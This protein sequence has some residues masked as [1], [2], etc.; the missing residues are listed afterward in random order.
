MLKLS[1]DLRRF[2]AEYHHPIQM[3]PTHLYFSALPFAPKSSTL[4]QIFAKVFVDQMP[5]VLTGSPARWNDCLAVMRGSSESVTSVSFS[6]DGALIA[7][8]AWDDDLIRLWDGNTGAPMREFRSDGVVRSLSFVPD[9]LACLGYSSGIRDLTNGSL[10]SKFTIATNVNPE[11][12]ST[13]IMAL[14]ADGRLMASSQG[15]DY[16]GTSLRP[17]RRP[18]QRHNEFSI[19][20]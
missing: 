19:L 3:N 12:E 7:S 9:G 5:S 10:T 20:T 11:G 16:C 13:V 4:F 1:Y 15:I 18:H 8:I 17:R 2:V 14:S 6:A